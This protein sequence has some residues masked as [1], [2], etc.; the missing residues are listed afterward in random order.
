[1]VILI[2]EKQINKIIKPIKYLYKEYKE[3]G[4]QPKEISSEL[5]KA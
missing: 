4:L 3:L 1:M 2:E 5:T